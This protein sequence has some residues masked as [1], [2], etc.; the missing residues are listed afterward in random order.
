[1][2]LRSILHMLL[3]PDQG[4]APSEKELQAEAEF[5]KAKARLS[6]VHDAYRKN[7]GSLDALR[8]EIGDVDRLMRSSQHNG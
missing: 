7:D 5:S 3:H 1:M 4:P 8:D 6:K 2:T